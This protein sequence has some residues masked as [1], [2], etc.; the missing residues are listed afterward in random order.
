MNKMVIVLD[1]G[2]VKK[3]LAK[4]RFYRFAC[5]GKSCVYWEIL[6]IFKT[7]ALKKLNQFILKGRLRGPRWPTYLKKII[8]MP[9]NVTKPTFVKIFKQMGKMVANTKLSKY[10]FTV[11][12]FI[13]SFESHMKKKRGTARKRIN[14]LTQKKTWDN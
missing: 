9:I 5:R 3:H 7:D 4:T 11:Q 6:S 2:E 13:I 10:F 1:L 14:F 8:L 12:S